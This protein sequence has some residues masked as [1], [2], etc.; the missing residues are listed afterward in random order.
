MQIAASYEGSMFNL[1]S[2][3]TV[4]INPSASAKTG[5]TVKKRELFHGQRRLDAV[6]KITLIGYFLNFLG[7]ISLSGEPSS[8]ILVGQNV[9]R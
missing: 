2:V 8:I 9:I 4:P 5:Y 3:P 6:S 7:K 1:Y